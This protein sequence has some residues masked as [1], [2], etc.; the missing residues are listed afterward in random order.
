MTERR[1]RKS[2]TQAQLT[3]AELAVTL[4]DTAD[5]LEAHGANAFR[6]RAYR[7]AADTI[8]KMQAPL[9]HTLQAEGI[10]GLMRLPAI[11]NS[12]A[13]TLAHLLR[14]GRFPLLERLR[15]GDA[16]E[17]LFATVAD[18]GPKLAQRI[19]EQLGIETLWELESAAND[20]RLAQVPGIGRKRLRAVRESLAG[21]FHRSSAGKAKSA[22]TPDV[23]ASIGELLDVDREYRELAKSG[24]LPRIAPRHFNPTGA[25]WLPVLHTERGPRHYTALYSNTARAHELGATH[26]WVVIYRDDDGSHGQWTVITSSFGKLQ[27]KRIVRG[28][29]TACEVYYDGVR[30]VAESHPTQKYSQ[31]TLIPSGVRQ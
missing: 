23:D 1:T 25:A 26:D 12:I 18:I 8:D 5:L 3:N 11:G 28:R 22:S 30:T 10:T 14:T 2:A 16:S 20:G 29:E 7:N 24:Q 13:G 27:G 17:R 31:L 6:V 21:R 15:G 9:W 4:R 19:H